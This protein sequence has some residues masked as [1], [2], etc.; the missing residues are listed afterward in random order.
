MCGVDDR[1]LVAALVAGDPR[2]LEGAYR[3]YA[4]RIYTYC[5]GVLRDPD[6]AADAVHDTFVLASQRAHQLR[7]PAR[8]RSWLYAIARNECLRLLR[9]RARGVPLEAAGQMSAPETDPVGGMR[10]AEIQELVWAAAAGLNPGDREVFDLAVRHELPAQEIGEALGIS[11]AHAHA[12]LSRARTQLERALGALLVA[13]TGTGDCPELAG[14]LKGWD[15]EL[16]ALV[17]KRL[18]RHIDSCEVC[19]E[20][21]R[22][23]L[24]PAALFAAYAGAPFLVAP[25]E[26][27][28]RLQLTSFDP[29]H[30]PVREAITSRAGRFRSDTGFPRPL[31]V[32]RRRLAVAGV[33]AVAVAALLAAGTGA[34]I[35]PEAPLAGAPEPPPTAAALAP[36]PTA[37][38]TPSPPATSA[39]AA[40]GAPAATPGPAGP[41]PPPVPPPPVPPPASPSPPAPAP[42]D[43]TV[44]V[45]AACSVSSEEFAVTV[46][47]TANQEPVSGEF[48]VRV[49]ST[50][51]PPVPLVISGNEATATVRG[52]RG[53]Q[54]EWSVA[55]GFPG[56]RFQDSGRF[57]VSCEGP[58][59]RG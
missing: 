27:W 38:A 48:A 11:V 29:G 16:T 23:Q 2:G 32:R 30:A 26:L 42:L 53:S 34:M 10:A 14:L 39:P 55:V 31:D 46:T 45:R 44:D 41:P 24:Q 8:L 6:A 40:T 21:R 28:P 1:A 35:A 22:R 19:G 57:E 51:W 52:L 3:A 13:R 4:D 37:T 43:V 47:V 36:S 56:E 15:G 59:I 9:G 54:V 25:V 7:D 5:R 17:R 33:S 50:A 58:V 49:G 18:S 12:R 20:R